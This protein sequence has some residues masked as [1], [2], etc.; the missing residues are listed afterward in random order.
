M[1]NKDKIKEE[2]LEESG[3]SDKLE[4]K[5][6]VEGWLVH[7]PALRKSIENMIDLTIK[8]VNR[9]WKKKIENLIPKI[10][11]FVFYN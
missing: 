8:K 3:F 2:V 6:G 4:V 7:K 5:K 1:S 10:F 9:D 11:S